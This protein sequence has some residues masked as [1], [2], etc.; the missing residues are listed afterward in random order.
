[1]YWQVLV[2]LKNAPLMLAVIYSG[3]QKV[4][5]SPFFCFLFGTNWDDMGF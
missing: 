1:M 4:A 3:M 5:D 2:I